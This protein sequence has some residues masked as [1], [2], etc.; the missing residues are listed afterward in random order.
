MAQLDRITA[1][2]NEV[3]QRIAAAAARNGRTAGDVQLVAVTK[4]VNT[5]V[6]R[7]LIDAGCHHLGESR[8]QDLWQKA[9]ELTGNDVHWHLIGHL[10]RNKIRRTLPLVDCIQS[11]DSIHTL[12]A[13]DRIADE[14]ELRARVLIEI[15]VSGDASKDGL[16]LNEA[17]AFLEQSAEMSHVQ[18]DGLMCMAALDGDEGVARRNFA[19]L[20]DLRDRL[21]PT[22]LPSI[23]LNELSMGMSGDYEI[24]IEEGATMVRVG[25]ALFEGIQS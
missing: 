3:R 15:N 20:R 22:C 13:I 17:P 19:D 11:I 16:S 7:L 25:S 12:A 8:P 5:E 24:A 4:Y 1:N 14:L 10:Q 6:S 2:L 23:R 9:D 18:I 21:Q